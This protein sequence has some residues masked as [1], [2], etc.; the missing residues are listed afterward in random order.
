MRA[1]L[2]LLFFIS[3]CTC[4]RAQTD[5]L[6][7][8]FDLQFR[9]W[10]TEG[11]VRLF[12][13]PTTM[14]RWA[15]Y[16]WVGYK[17]ERREQ[18]TGVW[19][20]LNET[21]IQEMTAEQVEAL[22]PEGRKRQLTKEFL[23]TPDGARRD[24][25]LDQSDPDRIMVSLD[26]QAY[27]YNLMNMV[28]DLDFDASR[29]FGLGY[30]DRTAEVDKV[31]DYRVVPVEF[32]EAASESKWIIG[33]QVRQLVGLT[34]LRAEN[35]TDAV[36]LEWPHI[37]H[38]YTAYDVFRQGDGEGW[39]EL[40]KGGIPS[41]GKDDK[42]PFTF[43]DSV[44]QNNVRYQY[45]VVGRN[46]LGIRAPKSN[47][48]SAMGKDP[49]FLPTP[50]I[51]AEDGPDGITISWDFADDSLTNNIAYFA[52][53]RALTQTGG[54]SRVAGPLPPD[55]RTY[56]DSVFQDFQYYTVRAY[57]ESGAYLE[58]IRQRVIADDTIPP[59]PPTDLFAKADRE[60][61][62]TL[63]WSPSLADD[64]IGYRV[65]FS[66]ARETPGGRMTD[67]LELIPYFTDSL[68][69]YTL[70]DSVYYR[71]VALDER[72]NVGDFSEPFALAVPDI[73]P[74]APPRLRTI[75]AD[76]NG[77]VLSWAPSSSSDVV[78]YQL[79]RRA[80]GTN[81]W[82]VFATE[83]ATTTVSTTRDATGRDD[84]RYEYQLLAIDEVGLRGYSN[85]LTGKRLIRLVRP[86]VGELTGTAQ[87]ALSRVELTWA[88]P[89]DP[90][91]RAFRILRANPDG[92]LKTYRLI[93]AENVDRRLARRSGAPAQWRFNDEELRRDTEY[94]YAVQVEFHNGGKSRLGEIVAVEY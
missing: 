76:T 12:W 45:A 4:V 90:G 1:L 47:Y 65:F 33:G 79:Q 29:S 94:R 60:G 26:Q 34:G 78:R 43:L 16:R 11:E 82:E 85:I 48:A 67:T 41:W 36:R 92:V 40:T 81:Y 53:Y 22:L 73:V 56:V 42:L 61:R 5:T 70:G 46:V 31:Y 32:P 63:T 28:V 37:S 51:E 62:V 35:L 71:V 83:D 18:S 54:A 19:T 25:R 52:V 17:V 50:L 80:L 93:D 23:F 68:D 6:A 87:P 10:P 27:G 74:P 88:Y 15:N 89:S 20:V 58:S 39:T 91:I 59:P 21:P 77:V 64:V 86:A 7:Q 2:A 8:D 75:T 14:D 55:Q 38:R 44:P 49:V 66:N 72:E 30:I 84:I 9:I 13:W 57:H 69:L 3:L 24:Y